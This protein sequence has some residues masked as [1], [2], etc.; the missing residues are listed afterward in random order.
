MLHLCVYFKQRS[1]YKDYCPICEYN[2][3][4]NIKLKQFRLAFYIFQYFL[5]I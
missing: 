2:F 4:N 1:E 3:N 5:I